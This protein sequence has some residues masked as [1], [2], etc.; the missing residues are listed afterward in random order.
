LQITWFDERNMV[1]TEGVR[2]LH[3]LMEDGKRF[4]S[5]S[6]LRFRATTSH[7]GKNVTCQA[8]NAATAQP[9]L[10]STRSGTNA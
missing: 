9:Q 4:V 8:Q 3:E 2:T 7:N 10:I 5:V 6:I 1:I